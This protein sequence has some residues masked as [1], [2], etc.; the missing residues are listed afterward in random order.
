MSCSRGSRI[1]VS[2]GSCNVTC[3]SFELL[4]QQ[5]KHT[6]QVSALQRI[7]WDKDPKIRYE[8]SAFVLSVGTQLQSNCSS[9]EILLRNGNNM[10]QQH[11]EGETT[12]SEMGSKW[13]RK[14]PHAF[15]STPA[16]VE[17]G[18]VSDEMGSQFH[19]VWCPSYMYK[20]NDAFLGVVLAK[21]RNSAQLKTKNGAQDKRCD[22]PSSD[23]QLRARMP[24]MCYAPHRSLIMRAHARSAFAHASTRWG[25]RDCLG[26]DN[27]IL[28]E[29]YVRV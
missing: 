18:P 13:D 16:G 23:I 24:C 7:S 22:V 21:Y 26:D 4:L 11:T 28:R 2:L 29:G 9:L 19:C 27:A 6:D 5:S 3:S 25:Q 15:S 17:L 10:I 1:A 8:Y 20:R 12:Q 14:T